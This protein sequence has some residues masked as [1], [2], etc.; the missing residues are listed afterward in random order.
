MKN[1]KERHPRLHPVFVDVGV[2]LLAVVI[3]LAVSS[4]LVRT[5]MELSPLTVSARITWGWPGTT[6]IRVPP[7]G[8]AIANSHLGPARLAVTIDSVD[9]AEVER[10]IAENPSA[11]DSGLPQF[12]SAGS[13]PPATVTDVVEQRGRTMLEEV[14]AL[15]VLSALAAGVVAVGI[16]LAARRRWRVVLAAAVAASGLVVA[17]SVAAATTFDMA[18]LSELRLQGALASVPRLASV[19]SARVASIERLRDQAAVVSRQIAAYYANPRSIA[20]GGG[21]PGTYRVLHITDLHLDPV[22]AELAASLARSYE[23]SLVINTGDI[24]ITGAREESL[25]LSSLVSTATPMIY[26][27]GNHDSSATILAMSAIPDVTVATSTVVRDGLTILAIP[28]P[29]SL[30]ADVHPDPSASRAAVLDALVRLQRAKAA[31]LRPPDIIALHDPRSEREL[32]GFTPLLL[33]GH[34]HSERL[35][36]S[37]GTVRLNSGTLG[38]MPYDPASIQRATLPHSASVLY[39]TAEQPRRLIAIDLISVGG[40]RTTTMTRHVVDESLLPTETAP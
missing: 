11:P 19:F 8:V 29:K 24:S 27:P 35:Y 21:L 30:S 18:S 5:R 31:G 13:P 33:A 14:I 22:G 2:V 3:G 7:F 36:V 39:Y 32:A 15:V 26:V 23:A 10:L 12:R 28:D 25:L 17:G 9:L 6:T 37:E 34:T 16:V 1:T 4:A 38:G 40:D 20:A